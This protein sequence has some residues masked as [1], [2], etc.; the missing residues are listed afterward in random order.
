L[1]GRAGGK[2][3]TLIRLKMAV[4]LDAVMCALING[5][6]WQLRHLVC[7]PAELDGYLSACEVISRGLFYEVPVISNVIQARNFLQWPSPVKSV[8]PENDIARARIFLSPEG[9]RAPTVI[10]LHALMSAHDF[11]YCRIATRLNCRGW[12]ALLMHLPYHYSR[13]PRGY[14]NGA[15][16]LTA[17]LPQNAETMR[18]AVIEV[19]QMMEFF[20]ANGCQE[21]GII[22]TSY[23]GWVGAL[24]SF[25]ESDFRFVAL[26]QPIADI[27]HAIWDSP[28][29]WAIRRTLRAAGIE[30][31]ASRRHAHLTSP[32][33]GRPA[34]DRKRILIVAGEH[35]KITPPSVLK[36]LIGIWPESHLS[37]VT[38][39][40]FGYAAMGEALR[41]VERLL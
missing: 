7:T 15:L 27:E 20:R 40:H 12:N 35:D 36:E 16:A 5:V 31:G 6:Q 21:F 28:A 34:C 25:L 24:L 10:F 22:G 3:A 17:N 32:L 18:Q 19:R 2:F 8:F 9:L 33:D 38:Q 37:M 26:L 39:G 29:S 4:G 23:G 1:K 14:F 13:V 41:W 30:R 11:G